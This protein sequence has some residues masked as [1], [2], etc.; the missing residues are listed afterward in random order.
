MWTLSTY[1]RNERFKVR[2]CDLR[3]SGRDWLAEFLKQAMSGR[4]SMIA[5][6]SAR[7]LGVSEAIPQPGGARPE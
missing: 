1:E 3:Q 2:R 6:T 7:A 4:I 5:L